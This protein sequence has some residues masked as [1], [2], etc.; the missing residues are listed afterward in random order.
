MSECQHFGLSDSSSCPLWISKLR[1]ILWLVG[2]AVVAS[3]ADSWAEAA[4]RDTVNTDGQH[5]LVVTERLVSAPFHA[6]ARG[7]LTAGVITAATLSTMVFDTDVRRE[8]QSWDASWLGTVDDVGHTFQRVDL[9]FGTTALIYAAGLSPNRPTVR[10][11]GEDLVVA[12]AVASTGT[13]VVKHLAGR[14]RPNQNDGPRRFIGPTLDDSH[15]SFWSGDVTTA[16]TLASVLSAEIKRPVAT[17]LLY[18]LATTTAVQRI[19]TDHHW[20]SD[21]ACA[22]VWSTAVGI[23]TVKL[24]RKLEIQTP[25][26]DSDKGLKL[27]LT[28]VGLTATW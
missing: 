9:F 17:V 18:G 8:V 13:Q 2:L 16:F 4:W 24:S 5:M 11:V 12:F 28:P 22:A 25:K 26:S 27:E 21:V 10:R 14:A 6:P 1:I 20:F 19:H 23:G 3:P 7:W 15:Q